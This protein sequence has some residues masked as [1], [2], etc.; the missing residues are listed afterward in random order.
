MAEVREEPKHDWH[1]IGELVEEL[2]EDD[3]IRHSTHE[4]LSSYH[5]QLEARGS[6]TDRQVAT[7][8]EIRDRRDRE[9][10][11]GF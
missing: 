7:I 4:F 3:A 8:Y 5:E 1:Q 11:R 2:L 6:L 9:G 10:K